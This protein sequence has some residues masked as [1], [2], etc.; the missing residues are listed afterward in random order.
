MIL[1]PFEIQVRFSDIDMMGHVNNSVYLSYFE[2]ARVYYLKQVFG[3]N[4][5][6]GVNGF[7]LA[8]TEIDYIKPIFLNDV[9][10]IEL[11]VK[12]IGNKSLSLIYT[13]HVNKELRSKGMSVLV[14][15]NSKENLSYVLPQNMREALELLI[16]V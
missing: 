8:R 5:D 6:Y 10:K 13:I 14:G 3:E 7:L 11:K 12:N 1:K 15:F 9:P 2:M 16:E 4:W